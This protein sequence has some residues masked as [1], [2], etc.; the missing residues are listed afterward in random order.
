MC[1]LITK[2]KFSLL[3][4][5]FF[6]FVFFIFVCVKRRG[7]KWDD[8]DVNKSPEDYLGNKWSNIQEGTA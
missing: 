4:I 3:I 8:V 2:V 7:N 6:F 1:L 5:F